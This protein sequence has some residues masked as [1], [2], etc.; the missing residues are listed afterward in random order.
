MYMQNVYAKCICKKEC[1][2]KCI[3]KCIYILEL[4]GTKEHH[5][6]PCLYAL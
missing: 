5:K 6:G 2:Y 1:I 4:K 3:F